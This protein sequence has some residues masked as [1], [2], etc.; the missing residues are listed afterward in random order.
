MGWPKGVKRGPRKRRIE[1]LPHDPEAQFGPE[2]FERVHPEYAQSSLGQA[3]QGQSA[4]AR[5]PPPETTGDATG[6]SDLPSHY[7]KAMD[8]QLDEGPWQNVRCR[9]CNMPMYTRNPAKRDVCEDCMWI[10]MDK[11]QEFNRAQIKRS[12]N[13]LV[14][15]F[16]SNDPFRELGGSL[17]SVKPRG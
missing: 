8:W 12:E 15:P 13:R 3:E 7:R 4:D 14:D 2:A 5:K 9:E 16:R 11:L 10:I 17:P 6:L 1:I